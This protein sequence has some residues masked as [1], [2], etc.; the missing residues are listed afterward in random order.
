MI[1]IETTAD[2]FVNIL[3]ALPK[4]QQNAIIVRIAQDEEFSQDVL[5][6]ATI[7]E[8]RKEP[9]RSF[10]KYLAEKHKK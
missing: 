4:S 2:S 10:H 8:R 9:S 1:S 6:L 5:D 7:A 3:K